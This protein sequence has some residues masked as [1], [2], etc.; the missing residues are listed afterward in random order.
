VIV[1]GKLGPEK[2]KPVPLNEAALIV[3]EAVPDEVAVTDLATPD[4]TFTVP[5]LKLVALKVS[6]GTVV[7]AHAHTV[8][9]AGI[10]L[11]KSAR[12]TVLLHILERGF[13]REIRALLRNAERF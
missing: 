4:P 6:V 2:T 7:A 3:T 9:F 1:V 13:H 5:K 12:N 11:H 10:R 8:R